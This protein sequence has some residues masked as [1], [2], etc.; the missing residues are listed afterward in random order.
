MLGESREISWSFLKD[1]RDANGKRPSD[2]GYDATTILA[3]PNSKEKKFTPAQEQYWGIKSKHADMILF[4]KV[5]KF[6]ELF[7]EDA[8]IGRMRRASNTARAPPHG[9]P[10]LLLTP[11]SLLCRPPRARPR[12]HGQ[13]GAA[14][15][16]PGG[17]DLEVRAEARGDR[18]YE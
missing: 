7:E 16:L 6:Y 11:R 9:S 1:K 18:T 10:P 8:L 15:R 17:G 12:L 2:D 13:G 4:F 5:G 3:K 14:R